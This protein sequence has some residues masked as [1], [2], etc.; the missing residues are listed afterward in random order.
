MASEEIDHFLMQGWGSTRNVGS[1]V[2]SGRPCSGLDSG[3]NPWLRLGPTHIERGP[4][5]RQQN[6]SGPRCRRHSVCGSIRCDGR[7]L[8][9]QSSGRGRALFAAWRTFPANIEELQLR[10]TKCEIAQQPRINQHL[11]T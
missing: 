2:W 7:R 1:C 3:L 11:G 6:D 5:L 9:E 8:R 10:R 4:Y